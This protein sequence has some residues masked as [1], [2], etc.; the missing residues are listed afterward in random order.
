MPHVNGSTDRSVFNL[1]LGVT[2]QGAVKGI[3]LQK[4]DEAAAAI[5]KLVNQRFRSV[6]PGMPE[7]SIRI[8]A[9]LL[10][11]SVAEVD[12]AKTDLRAVTSSINL[13]D[14]DE[15]GSVGISEDNEMFWVEEKN[16]QP[17][18]GH[19]AI[20][21][22]CKLRIVNKVLLQISATPSELAF[23]PRTCKRLVLSGFISF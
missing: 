7:R 18:N 15:D 4:P 23:A 1:W 3:A 21:A 11:L 10:A 9:H 5:I 19:S 6:Y 13:N 14:L 22:S 17:L 12:V 16:V 20:G 2:D 8:T